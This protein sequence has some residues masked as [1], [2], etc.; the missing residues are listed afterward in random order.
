MRLSVLSCLAAFAFFAPGAAGAFDVRDASSPRIYVANGK[1]GTIAE[2]DPSTLALVESSKPV[3]PFG[4]NVNVVVNAQASAWFLAS[5]FYELPTGRGKQALSTFTAYAPETGPIA[6]DA[7]G[8][9]YA[10]DDKFKSVDQFAEAGKSKKRRGVRIEGGGIGKGGGLP[11]H[12]AIDLAG[13]LWATADN[14]TVTLFSNQKTTVWSYPSGTIFDDIYVDPSGTVWVL[15]QTTTTVNFPYYQSCT[16][17]PSGPIV[18]YPVATGFAN[19]AAT[20][21]LYGPASEN[22]VPAH[23]VVDAN[24]RVY[25]STSHQVIDYDPG[26]QCPNL[27]LTIS[28]SQKAVLAPL[29]VYGDDLLVANPV[30]NTI[31]AY[32]GGSTTQLW[33]ITQ[34]SGQSG[35]VS[36]LVR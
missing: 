27:N 5:Q 30:T 10:I 7:A 2:Y 22:P 21:T 35:P 14:D 25:V 16:P 6:I 9:L 33:Q 23:V 3:A 24:E 34:P 12:I 28:F 13:N 32:K 8:D 4:G 17:E 26:T 36:I 31:D 20:T 11:T 15:Y 1:S 29:A 18:R 19:G